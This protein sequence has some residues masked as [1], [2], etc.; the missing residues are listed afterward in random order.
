MLIKICGI[1]RVEDA[2]RAVDLGVHA[3]GFVLWRGS[4]RSVTLERVT[5]IASVV[6]PLVTTVGV[7]VD[8]ST[9]EVAS[10][11]ESGIQVAQVVGAVP[12]APRGMRVVQVAHLSGDDGGITPDIPGNGPIL[13]DAHD[14]VRRGGTGRV[15]D[16]RRARD[17]AARRP[18]ILAGGL[19]PA[20][21]AAAIETVGPIG[22]DVSS[23]VEASPGIKDPEKLA[24]FVAA[25]RSHP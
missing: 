3:L 12:P 13:L 7:F 20:N 16:W 18:V 19:S 25:V 14:P 21:V 5:A 2:Q 11:R 8:P 24:A 15:I 17:V 22:V 4:P 10:A 9:D 1:T 23:G 6:A